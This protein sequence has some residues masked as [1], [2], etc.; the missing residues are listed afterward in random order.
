VNPIVTI[1]GGG[2]IG[3]YISL[4]LNKSNIGSIIIEKS[5]EDNHKN[6]NIR[7][8]TLNPFSKKLLDDIGI[9]IPL[10]QIKNINVFDGDGSGKIDFSA[11]E[12]DEENL[13]YVAFFDEL[14]EELQKKEELKTY[15]GTQ[16]EKINSDDSSGLSE[17][18][19]SN[20]KIIKTKFIAGCEGRGSK[21]AKLASLTEIEG[22]YKQT[23]ITFT[24]K[25]KLSDKGKAHQIFSEKGIFAIMPVPSNELGSTHTVVWSVDNERLN[26]SDIKSYV[27]EN[28]SYFEKKLVSDIEINSDV[29]SFKLFNHHFKNYISGPTVLIGDAAHSIHPLAGQG[30]NLGFADADAFCEEII[31]GYEKSINIDQRLVLK[32]YEIRRKNMNLLMLKSMDFFVNIFRSENLY[33]KLLRNIGL[34]NVNK[35]QFLKRFFI[36]HAS[37]KNKI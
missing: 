35:N 2:I 37:G 20:N 24:V 15:F 34:S 22:N 17:I 36:N 11:K 28:I 12:V 7:T 6:K 30:I 8:L 25:C 33:L 3:N 14:Q 23:A 29:L 19:L 21:V 26:E 4:R 10:A 31:K 13:S 1:S 16:I 27:A 9:N 18:Y 32:K 5:F